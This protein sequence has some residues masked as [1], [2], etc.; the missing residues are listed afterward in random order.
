MAC[1][2]TCTR[3]QLRITSARFLHIEP[4]PRPDAPADLEQRLLAKV[5]A[6]LET[7]THD[8]PEGTDCVIGEPLEVCTRN[9]IK[10]VTDGEYTAWYEVTL[11]KYRTSGELMPAGDTLPEGVR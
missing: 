3:V 7:D 1:Q 9:Q 8:G 6:A 5:R 11:V 4:R 2:A 10:R